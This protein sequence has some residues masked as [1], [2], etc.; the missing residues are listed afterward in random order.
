VKL[1]EQTSVY[2]STAVL[3]NLFINLY[4]CGHLEPL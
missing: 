4:K 2:S 3:M 1:Y